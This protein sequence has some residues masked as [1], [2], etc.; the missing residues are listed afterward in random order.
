MIEK[1]R[2][3]EENEAQE[4]NEDNNI[5]TLIKNIR[6]DQVLNTWIVTIGGAKKGRVYGLGSKTSVLGEL[7][8]VS[9][10]HSNAPTP[11]IVPPQQV[12]ERPEFEQAVN[13]VVDQREDDRVDQRMDQCMELMQAHFR[14]EVEAVHVIMSRMF[15]LFPQPPGN[16]SGSSSQPPPYI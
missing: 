11:P 3:I 14:E 1:R 5:L 12:I 4:C 16:G 8:H 15:G 13:H 6:K 2:R 7:T 9:S 10:I